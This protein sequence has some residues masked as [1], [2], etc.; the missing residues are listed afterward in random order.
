MVF[1]F[2]RLKKPSVFDFEIIHKIVR[3]LLYRAKHNYFPTI[4]IK[5]LKESDRPLVRTSSIPGS[6]GVGALNDIALFSKDYIN[7]SVFADPYKSF[8]NYLVDVDGNTILLS[9]KPIS[10][11]D[12]TSFFLF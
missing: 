11:N 1:I 8:G 12:S 9:L 7:Y 6:K 4:D 3:K 5:N 10:F 2:H